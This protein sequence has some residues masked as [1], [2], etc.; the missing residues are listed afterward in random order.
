MNEEQE[1]I[2]KDRIAELEGLVGDK[3]KEIIDLQDELKDANDKVNGLETSIKGLK[4][5]VDDQGYTILN[6]I[7]DLLSDV[8]NY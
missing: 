5:I 3:E 7:K 6:N 4:E 1:K 8:K 2:Y